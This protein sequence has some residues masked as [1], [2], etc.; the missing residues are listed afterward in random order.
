[1]RRL[2]TQALLDVPLFGTHWRWNATT[3]LAVR[4]YRSGNKILPQFQ[5]S[6]AEDL[7][8]LIFPDQLACLE[9]L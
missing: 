6:A 5:R 8:A 2:L 3:A 4:R 7:V 9:N 1:M